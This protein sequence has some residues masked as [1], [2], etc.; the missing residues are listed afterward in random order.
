MLYL[1]DQ[2]PVIRFQSSFT[3]RWELEDKNF[4]KIDIICLDDSLKSR[5]IG[6]KNKWKLRTFSSSIDFPQGTELGSR[7][8]IDTRLLWVKAWS[9]CTIKIPALPT[10]P[11]PPPT[12]DL[13]WC[14]VEPRHTTIPLLRPPCLRGKAMILQ[15][16]PLLPSIKLNQHSGA[17]FDYSFLFLLASPSLES[18]RI[19]TVTF[20][21]G[22]TI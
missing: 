6:I 18:S 9:H 4:H 16:I 12:R 2:W 20:S 15:Q 3:S 14:T 17:G 22:P 8:W 7:F 13:H 10:S 19:G 1:L 11:S 5:I 21:K